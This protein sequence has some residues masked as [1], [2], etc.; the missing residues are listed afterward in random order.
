MVE[1]LELRFGRPSLPGFG[2]KEMMENTVMIIPDLPKGFNYADFKLKITPIGNVSILPVFALDGEDLKDDK[3]EKLGDEALEINTK[4]RK[5]KSENKKSLKE[6]VNITLNNKTLEVF[7]VDLEF[8]CN[9]EISFGKE[10]RI[11][12]K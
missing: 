1:A 4:V 12:L 3:L 9:A 2:S 8:V 11:D 5:I 7:K 6:P 10:F